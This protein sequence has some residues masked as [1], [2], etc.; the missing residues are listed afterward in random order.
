MRKMTEAEIHH[1]VQ[2]SNWATICTVSPEGRPYAV[3]ATYFRDGESFGFMI[4][5]RGRTMQNLRLNP[6][7][8]LKITQASDDLST[9]TGVS[10]FGTGHNISDHFEIRKGWT[11]LGKVMKTDYSKI[12]EKLI[13]HERQSPYLRCTISHSTGRCG[14]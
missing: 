13:S 3:E 5:P 10:L 8:L 6:N 1:V 14:K 2:N 12:A 11:L 7:L 9:W 4:N